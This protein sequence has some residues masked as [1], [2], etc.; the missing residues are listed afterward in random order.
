MFTAAALN[1]INAAASSATTAGDKKK[2]KAAEYDDLVVAL[3]EEGWRPHPVASANSRREEE[4]RDGG[5]HPCNTAW[6]IMIRS[7]VA[8][9]TLVGE[10]FVL[11]LMPSRDSWSEVGLPFVASLIMLPMIGASVWAFTLDYFLDPDY[12]RKK[13]KQ[14]R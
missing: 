6:K 10:A 2:K 9:A 3:L 7:F 5:G 8:V 11:S 1:S 12:H 13:R 4:A 14:P